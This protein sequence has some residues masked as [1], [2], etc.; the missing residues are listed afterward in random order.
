MIII[1]VPVIIEGINLPKIKITDTIP[2]NKAVPIRVLW[3]LSFKV[4]TIVTAIYNP[5]IM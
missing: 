4:N 1:R 5:I 2:Q 3:F